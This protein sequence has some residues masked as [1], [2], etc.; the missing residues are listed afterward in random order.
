[1]ATFE[2][3]VRDA[4]G[5]TSGGVLTAPN[6][7]EATRLLRRD[8]RTVLALHEQD[9]DYSAYYRT[10]ARKKK[11]RRDDIIF[12]AT[13]LAVMVDTGVPLSE[14]LDSITS[15]TDHEGLRVVVDDISDQIKSGVEFS[16]ALEKYPK[17]FDS[18]FVALMRA[19]E[20]SGTMGLMLE[21]ISEYLAKER[22]TR[23]KIKG[24]MTYPAC[25]LTFCVVVVTA[26]MI[27]I[28]PRFEKIYAGKGAALPMPTKI[29]M[30]ISHALV[31]YWAV[32]LG[33]LI[34]AVVA[35]YMYL[36]T[37]DGRLMMDRIKLNVP[38]LGSMYRKGCLAR[39]LRTMATMST[40]GVNMLE[41]LDIT[42]CAAGNEMY[43]RV[44]RDLAERV[45]EGSS[46]SEELFD[47]KLMPRTI[48]QMISAG[49]RTGRLGEVMNRVAQFCEDDLNVAVKT[50]TNMIEP[51]MIIIMGLIVG[52]IAMALLLPVFSLS[53]VMTR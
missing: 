13:Q 26:M 49:E 36:R 53:K 21:R 31:D 44:W 33:G 3:Q 29:L 24:A 51:I 22:D 14:A 50:I 37:P 18:L 11:I 9:D 43:A 41:S 15:Q 47:C 42:A 38:I 25:M 2:Y 46:L 4:G 30:A 7:E 48:A 12:F 35:L 5:G 39:C 16:T 1:M 28:L 40:S 23:K 19:S 17:L 8:G 6:S 20:A 52:G 32:I 10:Q 34:A 45:T 27:F